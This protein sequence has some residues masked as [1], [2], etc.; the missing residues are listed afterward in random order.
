MAHPP[1]PH[2]APPPPLGE[3]VGQKG[4]F[5]VAS[6]PVFKNFQGTLPPARA[7]PFLNLQ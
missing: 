6:E 5:Q 3:A 1:H 2:E 4:R 7:R